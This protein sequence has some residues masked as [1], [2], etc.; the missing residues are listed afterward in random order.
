MEEL[1]SPANVDNSVHPFAKDTPLALIPVYLMEEANQSILLY[2][3]AMEVNFGSQETRARGNGILHLKWFP[4][5]QIEFEITNA[6]P[7]NSPIDFFHVSEK[8]DKLSLTMLETGISSACSMLAVTFDDSYKLGGK[9]ERVVIGESN[10]KLKY[11]LVHLVNFSDFTGDDILYVFK[12][13][14]GYRRS[15]YR[16][17]LTFEAEGWRVT[18]DAMNNSS[19]IFKEL[20]NQRGYAFTH[21]AKLEKVKTDEFFSTDEV[22]KF[23]LALLFF[24]SFVRGIY[25]TPFLPIGFDSNEKKVWELWKVSM[26]SSWTYVHSWFSGKHNSESLTAIFPNFIS[27]W[28]NPNWNNPLLWSIN[29]YV[30]SNQGNGTPDGRIIWVQSA[31][32]LLSWTYFVTEG[33]MKEE[34][35]NFS[36]LNNKK[37]LMNEH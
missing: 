19:Q 15:R 12:S 16:G 24:F 34:E 9:L 17:R 35:F 29:W 32:E 3:G 30:E 1:N 23:L 10:A 33:R 11:L 8:N 26:V 6:T 31:L 27:Y 28:N 5:I 14:S 13:A 22:E 36:I 21:T 7:V 37:R 25:S 18:V 20:D 2:E 4:S